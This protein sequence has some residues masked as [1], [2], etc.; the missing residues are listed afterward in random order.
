[1]AAPA[2]VPGNTPSL[3]PR[4]SQLLR[5]AAQGY[6]DKEMAVVLGITRETVNTYWKRLRS[7]HNAASRAQLLATVLTKGN[8][9]SVLE[10][11]LEN[12]ATHGHAS[13]E[14]AT[15][16]A[17]LDSLTT[18]VLFESPDRKVLYCNPAFVEVI[19]IP[20]DATLLLGTDCQQNLRQGAPLFKFP[21]LVIESTEAAVDRSVP[22]R[23]EH[24]AMADGRVLQRD[25][26]P[27][28][29]SGRLV[30]HLWHY[31]DVTTVAAKHQALSQKTDN[32]RRILENFRDG[33]IACDEDWQV[34]YMNPSAEAMFDRTANDWEGGSLWD[35][36]R[37]FSSPVVRKQLAESE[38]S[39]VAAT[40]E[41][42]FDEVGIW[43]KVRTSPSPEGMILYLRDV[44]E[45]R[46]LS[47]SLL[48]YVRFGELVARIAP[49]LAGAGITELP[50]L[51][52]MMLSELGLYMGANRLAIVLLNSSGI[53]RETPFEW[54]RGF[55]GSSVELGFPPNEK[56]SAWWVSR[57]TEMPVIHIPD[58][59]ALDAGLCVNSRILIE[60]GIREVVLVP[61]RENGVVLGY[62]HIETSRRL[63]GMD[64]R[65]PH[66]LRL[67]ADCIM[68]ALDRMGSLV[69]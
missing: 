19:G 44:T 20:V 33:L 69:R 43:L 58:V 10:T 55:E 50:R 14:G 60:A 4:E 57:L 15:L 39:G 8:S 38:R 56:S 52:R 37:F 68:G 40:F 12:L 47:R 21:V 35:I 49:P 62:I 2:H 27:V 34:D 9:S 54:R 5:L 25:Y 1:M 17:L 26:T 42:V 64:D 3:T 46:N 22:V 30:G 45:Q 48:D 32:I 18:G 61:I 7:K 65:T 53:V 28:S 63:R 67:I 59:T 13:E 36:H 6:T 66:V 41:T 24:I 51:I 16:R 11:A 31:R 23:G 29:A